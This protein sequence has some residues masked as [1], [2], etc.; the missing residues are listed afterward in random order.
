MDLHKEKQ[1]NPKAQPTQKGR[2]GHLAL[3]EE[4]VW[5]FHP[6]WMKPGLESLCHYLTWALAKQKPRLPLCTAVARPKQGG[7]SEQPVFEDLI[8]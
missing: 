3:V 2:V 4:R 6:R 7:H 5:P 1:T 8:C